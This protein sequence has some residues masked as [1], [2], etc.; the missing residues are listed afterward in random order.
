MRVELPPFYPI[1]DL[2]TITSP[3][4]DLIRI[5]HRAGIDLIQLREKKST[6]RRLHEDAKRLVACAS[7][8]GMRVIIND[9]A[10]IARLTGAHGAHLGQEDL[11]IED[12]RRLLGEDKI[13][14]V[15]CHN[16]IQASQ[17]QQSSADYVAIGPV[18]ATATK[19]RPDPV[20]STAE[21]RTIRQDV[22]KPLV[23]IGGITTENAR[24]L[25][26]I[27]IDSVA[28]IRHLFA[29]EDLSAKV[30]E[31]LLCSQAKPSR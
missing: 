20:V 10:D 31:F 18:A 22:H 9:R 16:S 11:P 29:A 26:E 28:V 17:A 12:A 6:S 8:Y 7:R 25:F 13:I 4:D 24:G 21:L 30:A 19:E 27:G 15:S 1:V 23:A 14:G 3:L 5:F 2:N